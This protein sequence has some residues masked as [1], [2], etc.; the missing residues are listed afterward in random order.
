[1]NNII[2]HYLKNKGLFIC[3]EGGEGS[4]KTSQIK[5]I[6]EILKKH[7][8][9]FILT[10][11]PGGT[12]LGEEI[13]KILV[14]GSGKKL[15]SFSELLCFTAARRQHVNEI[16]LPALN[17]GK[18]VLCDRFIDSTIVYQ[19]LV[20]GVDIELIEHL[21]KDFCFNLYPDLTILLDI[22]PNIGLKRKNFSNLNEDRFEQFGL[23]FHIN[24]RKAFLK[25]SENNHHRYTVINAD[26][27]KNEI[28]YLI[29]KN[30]NDFF[31]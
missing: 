7:N 18:V 28:S 4:G 5:L 14:S 8:I 16:I 12:Q 20:G 24:I 13:R 6:S 1:M 26:N 19:G 3:F 2:N 30:I 17:S 31:K 27:Q 9:P 10:R 15:D 23:N 21:H 29:E 22:D 25:V 11:E